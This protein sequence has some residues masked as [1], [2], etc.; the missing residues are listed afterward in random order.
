[1]ASFQAC[2]NPLTL[3]GKPSPFKPEFQPIAIQYP[4]HETLYLSGDWRDNQGYKDVDYGDRQFRR[5]SLI[6][7]LADQ[8]ST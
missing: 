2:A 7:A 1:M 3:V 6:A 8:Q 4:S 5:R